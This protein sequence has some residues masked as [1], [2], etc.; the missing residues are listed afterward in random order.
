MF[1]KSHDLWAQEQDKHKH[2]TMW[3]NVSV[4]CHLRCLSPDVLFSDLS[5][6]LECVCVFLWVGGGGTL[7]YGVL[8]MEL[9]VKCE[10]YTYKSQRPTHLRHRDGNH[11]WDMAMFLL[12]SCFALVASAL[13][14]WL[15]VYH[16][17]TMIPYFSVRCGSNCGYHLW[18]LAAC[19]STVECKH[20]NTQKTLPGICA[21]F[22][23]KKI[24]FWLCA[25]TAG[26]GV[27]AIKPQVSGYNK[28][29][30]GQNAVSGSWPWQVSLQ[31]A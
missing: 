23:D 16:Y 6:P 9:R 26:C 4:L 11:D 18:C 28:I 20:S 21:I 30:N 12:V 27:P 31:V 13:G 14:E 5:Q 1:A 8:H 29:V 19:T 7:L 15:A 10:W 22:W 25:W 24:Y 3:M 2:K 17:I